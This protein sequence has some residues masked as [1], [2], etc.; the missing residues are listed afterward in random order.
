MNNLQTKGS[1]KAVFV[2]GLH[3]SATTMI[4]FLA[5]SHSDC[6]ALGEVWNLISNPAQ[7]KRANEIDCSCGKYAAE[8]SFWGPLFPELGGDGDYAPVVAHFHK[9]YGRDRIM[10]DSSKHY[11]ACVAL[12][13][14]VDITKVLYCIRDVRG[15]VVSNR[16]PSWKGFLRWYRNNRRQRALFNATDALLV[17]Y[18]ELVLNPEPYVQKIFDHAGLQPTGEAIQF[19]LR[20]HHAIMC[21]RMKGD[22]SKMGGMKYDTRWLYERNFSFASLMLPWIIRYNSKN[23]YGNVDNL[24][25]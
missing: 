6:V 19:G 25:K 4:H 11:E 18:E 17:S 2:A 15:W 20:E 14:Q 21:N 12:S 16:L 8:C 7:L 13:Q 22:A 10:V 3:R 1:T 23:V 24:F 9:L 5:G